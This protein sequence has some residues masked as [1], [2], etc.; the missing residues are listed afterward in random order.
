MC[1]MDL[2]K[3]YNLAPMMRVSCHTGVMRPTANFCQLSNS[4]SQGWE[5]WPIHW[6]VLCIAFWTWDLN[7]LSFVSLITLF[8]KHWCFT[9]TGHW[10][11]KLMIPVVFFSK[12]FG[13]LLWTGTNK[14]MGMTELLSPVT[15][16]TSMLDAFWKTWEGISCKLIDYF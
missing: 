1:F 15:S 9:Q 11:G 10:V 2:R 6:L 12:G 5:L 3:A 16:E 7:R 8:P 14:R 13:E 4:I